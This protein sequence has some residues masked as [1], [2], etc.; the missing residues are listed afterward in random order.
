MSSFKLLSRGQTGVGRGVLDA[1]LE[2]EIP[3]SGWCPQGRGAED[4]VISEDYPLME[5]DDDDPRQ[6]TRKNV[7]ESDGSVIICFGHTEGAA[8]DTLDDCV[9]YGKV[10]QLLDADKYQAGQ[11]AKILVDF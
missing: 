2:L 1:A 10:Y 4:G 7:L 8:E 6:G 11:A 3:C 5:I 9:Q